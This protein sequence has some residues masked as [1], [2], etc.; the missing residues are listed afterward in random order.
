M[1]KYELEIL[2]IISNSCEHLS[3][4]EVYELLKKKYPGVVKAT[5]Y[6]N[7]N[8]LTD[9]GLIRRIVLDNNSCRYDRTMRHDHLVCIKCE[10]I[11]DVYLKDMTSSLK[12]E[13][14]VEVESYD[15]KINW[16]C[17]DCVGQYNLNN[18]LGRK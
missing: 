9:G 5:C 11:K 7:L 17:P 10:K 2:N 16:L 4:D 8:K 14:G 18:S 15:L 6:N 1:T 3:A 13:L 12:K